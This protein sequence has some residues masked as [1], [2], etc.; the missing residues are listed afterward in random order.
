MVLEIN[1]PLGLFVWTLF[2]LTIIVIALTTHSQ[3]LD[4]YVNNF[5][6]E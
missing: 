2:I 1:R 3:D 6:Q 5:P 4:E